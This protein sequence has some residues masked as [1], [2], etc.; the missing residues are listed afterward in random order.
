MEGAHRS[1]RAPLWARLLSRRGVYRRE[2]A[3][4]DRLSQPGLRLVQRPGV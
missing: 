1:D 2:N 4:D 3:N